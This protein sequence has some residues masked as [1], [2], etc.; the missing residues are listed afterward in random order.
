MSRLA[1]K[2]WILGWFALILTFWMTRNLPWH[3]DNYDQARHSYASYEMV[4]QNAWWH[5][6]TPRQQI[7]TKPPLASW[8]SAG[9]Y[10]GTGSWPW[11]W[12]LPSLLAAAAILALL[13]KGGFQLAGMAGA[14]LAT[15]AFSWNL[16]SL[17]LATLARTDMLLAFFI[18]GAGWLIWQRLAREEKWTWRDTLALTLLLSGATMTKGPIFQ[19]FL[20]GGLVVWAFIAPKHSSKR[21]ILTGYCIASVLSLIPFLVWA[22]SRIQVDPAFYEQVVVREFLGRFTTGETAVHNNQTWYFYLPHL[23]TTTAPWSL[24]FLAVLTLQKVRSTL[25]E[26]P[27]TL[28]L[29]CWALGG[30][31]IM[32]LVPSKRMD[33]IFP[34]IPPAA[35]FLAAVL[36]VFAAR[37]APWKKIL[38]TT[39]TLAV[40]GYGSYS[41]ISVWQGY[42]T[43][44][45]ALVT[46]GKSIRHLSDSNRWKLVLIEAPDEGL[47]LYAG[48]KRFQNLRHAAEGLRKGTWQV[49]MI[50]S[51]KL[52]RLVAEAGKMETLLKVQSPAR[53]D[54]RY[55]LVKPVAAIARKPVS[56]AR[57]RFRSHLLTRGHNPASCPSCI[58]PKADF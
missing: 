18:F 22:G 11:A 50:D 7:A 55:L 8:F 6:K 25:R 45:D 24:L 47:I 41:A 26:N 3:L 38:L 14:F 4:G 33:R 51:R 1:F 23:L 13:W 17:R 12:R 43:H 2:G 27:A 15:A 35:L 56:E 32:T 10:Y 49:A 52:P 58:M 30:L 28:W 53:E 48:E 39:G 9:F 20:L 16:L 57:V 21:A 46:F 42:Q 5:Q 40:V 37:F 36:P 29:L 34:V 31:L 44:R 54:L 19:A